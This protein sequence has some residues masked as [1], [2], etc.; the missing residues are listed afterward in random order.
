MR[1]CKRTGIRA[2]L[3]LYGIVEFNLSLFFTSGEVIRYGGFHSTA[4]TKNV[5]IYDQTSAPMF[6][7]DIAQRPISGEQRCGGSSGKRRLRDTIFTRG[8]DVNPML[9]AG[10]LVGE[11]PHH[12]RNMES[13]DQ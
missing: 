4:N 1:T 11:R 6:V 10:L 8:M 12:F 13:P 5:A 2:A 7:K 9:G 3:L